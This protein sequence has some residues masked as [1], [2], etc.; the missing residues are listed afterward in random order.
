MTRMPDKRRAF[1]R[2]AMP[3]VPALLRLA[4][5]LCRN[6]D[7]AQDLVQDAMVKAFRFF[8][9]FEQ[10]SNERAWLYKLTVNLFYNR[11]HQQARERRV[12]EQAIADDRLDRFVSDASLAPTR[13]PE[14]DLVGR[15]SGERLQA[16]LDALPPDFRAAV[17]LCDVEELAY[18]EIADV[19]G[20]P[21]GTVMSRI[22]RGRRL[23]REALEADARAAGI[24][25]DLDGYRRR[26]GEDA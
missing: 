4:T 22:Y 3:H 15:M 25:V 13:D 26:R 11:W 1:E 16:A 23:L 7:D 12:A 18:R 5:R 24:T 20:C 9:R 10:G 6:P 8:D 19:L 2:F 21:I 17:V 14:A